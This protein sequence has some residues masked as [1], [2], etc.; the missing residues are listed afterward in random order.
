MVDLFAGVVRLMK[1]D[2]AQH[3][4]EI[5][6]LARCRTRCIGK[7]RRPTTCNVGCCTQE[8]QSRAEG[9]LGQSQETESAEVSLEFFLASPVRGCRIRP[10]ERPRIYPR[11]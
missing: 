7:D 9:S 2:R 6:K 1:R 8:N 4:R 5:A 10:I 11:L 3:V